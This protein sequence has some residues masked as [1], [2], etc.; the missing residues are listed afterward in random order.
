MPCVERDAR[1]MRVDLLTSPGCPN[2]AAVRRLI[3][4]CLSEFG[5]G[6]EVLVE[7]VGGYTSPTV[8]VDGVDAMRPG[9][10]LAADACRLDLTTK[11]H[12][13]A[14]LRSA[15]PRGANK[16]TVHGQ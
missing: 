13:L 2:A 6:E 7:R 15:V 8:L 9:T 11:D 5:I 14:A 1:C 12:V 16:I 4:D 3:V 10:E